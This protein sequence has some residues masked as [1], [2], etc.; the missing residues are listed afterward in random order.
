LSSAEVIGNNQI[1]GES[2]LSSQNKEGRL[3]KLGWLTW[4]TC[5]VFSFV[6][7]YFFIRNLPLLNH[8]S[9][10]GFY[11][12][13]ILSLVYAA[14]GLLIITKKPTLPFGWLLIG[15]AGP[16]AVANFTEMYALYGFFVAPVQNLPGVELAGWLQTWVIYL[17]FPAPI[18]LL[19]ML[20]P[21]GRLPS[22]RWRW[23][24][25]FTIIATLLLVINE[26]VSGA[27]IPVYIMEPP[28]IL[29]MSN[30]TY[31]KLPEVL[32]GFIEIGWVLAII[33]LPL[34]LLALV[35][36]FRS[37][38]GIAR[39]Q[40]KWFVYFAAVGLMLFPV[41][42][43]KS[44]FVGNVVLVLII[45]MLPVGTT[46][47][48]LRHNLYDIDII[49]RRTLIYAILTAVLGIVYFTVVVLLQSLLGS[50]IGVEESP[51]VIVVST[52]TI[53]VLVN[54][55]HKNIQ[56]FIDRRFYRSK[57]NARQAID[58][59]SVTVRDEVDVERLAGTLLSVVEEAIQP[60]RASLWLREINPEEYK[61]ES[62]D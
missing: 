34:G 11:G 35:I 54:P 45:L 19:C 22:L 36:R 21:D 47:A 59:F 52:L 1:A 38:H 3:R 12:G 48:I 50:L 32:Q 60:V 20:F 16:A 44:E 29:P 2:V 53:A 7:L 24:A 57:Y 9:F 61:R 49:I 55:L 56:A 10:P 51:V 62:R 33:A 26:M 8:M 6:G 17:A 13:L 58:S 15:I 41:G 18:A 42:I 40:L 46:L 4:G 39:R 28:L 5:V 25:L 27:R 23:A 43:L 37:A 14:V 30:P 31:L